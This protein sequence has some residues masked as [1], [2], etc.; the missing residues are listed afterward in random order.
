MPNLDKEV[1]PKTVASTPSMHTNLGQ[2]FLDQENVD[3]EFICRDLLNNNV[4]RTI[5]AHKVVLCAASPV[6]RAMLLGP[7][8]EKGPVTISD[9]SY[10]AFKWLLWIIYRQK[11]VPMPTQYEHISFYGRD[12]YIAAQKY[13]CQKALVDIRQVI[14][15]RLR[16]FPSE[17]CVW[18]TLSEMFDDPL[19]R[20][21]ALN[22]FVS[23]TDEILISSDF[24]NI[25]PSTIAIIFKQEQLNIKNEFD[26]VK[27]L[28][29]Y[30]RHNSSVTLENEHI[31]EAKRHIRFLTLTKKQI[32]DTTVLTPQE[33][34]EILYCYDTNEEV[35]VM[36][37]LEMSFDKMMRD[38]PR[39]NIRRTPRKRGKQSK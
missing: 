37:T 21:S 15:G 11:I 7:L 35:S 12:I 5:G 24:R 30:L 16:D 3:C 34:I 39:P 8:K 25:L 27:A 1:K 29:S 6:F 38:K 31:I 13:D 19:I 2:S 14:V 23:K 32:R 28:E 20:F 22:A 4:K 17:A 18:F 26:L 9:V 33:K 10:Q 36:K